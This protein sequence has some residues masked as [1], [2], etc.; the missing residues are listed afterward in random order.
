MNHYTYDSILIKL[1]K[2]NDS[3]NKEAAIVLNM[4]MFGVTQ[5]CELVTLGGGHT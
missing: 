5:T 4:I 1:K 3:T 2:V